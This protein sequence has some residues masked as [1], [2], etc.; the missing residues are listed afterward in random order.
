ML[1]SADME[2]DVFS[3]F[4]LSSNVRASLEVVT[5]VGLKASCAHIQ[6]PAIQNRVRR[7]VKFVLKQEDDPPH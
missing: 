4:L 2:I 3:L 7:R 1:F 6:C 5:G